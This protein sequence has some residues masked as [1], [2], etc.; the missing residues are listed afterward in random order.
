MTNHKMQ[1]IM[2]RYISPTMRIYELHT[3]SAI[4]NHSEYAA[5]DTKETNEILT[6]KKGISNDYN[7]SLWSQ[8]DNNGT[9]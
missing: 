8:M 4:L 3:E 2:K 1:T 9:N 5:D 7:S 6:N